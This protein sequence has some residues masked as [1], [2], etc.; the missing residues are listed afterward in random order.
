M[1]DY[2]LRAADRDTMRAVMRAT[3]EYLTGTTLPQDAPT[4]TQG[5][6]L[7]G[8]EWFADEIGEF[9]EPTGETVE[10]ELGPQPV[11]AARPGW[12]VMLRWNGGD[13]R[14]PD[15]PAIEIVWSSDM[16]DEDGQTVSRPE[17]WTRVIA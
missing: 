15:H 1:V 2:A 14:P 5:R 16:L 13:E 4:P 7:T 10:T 9:F 17:W 12:H 8:T 11:M 6:S 3:Y